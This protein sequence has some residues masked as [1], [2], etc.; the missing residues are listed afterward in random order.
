LLFVSNLINLVDFYP[1]G[2]EFFYVVLSLV[3]L[4]VAVWMIFTI[5]IKNLNTKSKDFL[6]LFNIL[7][8]IHL[9]AVIRTEGISIYYIFYSRVRTD[10]IHYFAFPGNVCFM[11]TL[12]AVELLTIILLNIF[13]MIK[14]RKRLNSNLGQAENRRT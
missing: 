14:K 9:F 5:Y 13:I 1:A 4:M 10:G 8:F 11:R 2:T 7:T 6:N 3:R 12:V